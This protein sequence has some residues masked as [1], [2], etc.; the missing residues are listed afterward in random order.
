MMRK[1]MIMALSLLMVGALIFALP[2]A[3]AESEPND[4]FASAEMTGEVTVTGSVN[5]T[6]TDFFRFTIPSEKDL[7]MTLKKTD[8]GAG[9]ISTT[10]YDDSQMELFFSGISITASVQ[11]V[12]KEESYYNGAST[13]EVIYIEITGDGEYEFTVEYTDDTQ[14]AVEGFLQACGVATLLMICGPILLIIII[15]VI[16]VIIVKKKKK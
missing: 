10:T 6:D 4:D 3:S 9:T 1:R 13:E 2:L 11:G 14:E 12:E 7:V 15:I 8:S 5:A 16:I